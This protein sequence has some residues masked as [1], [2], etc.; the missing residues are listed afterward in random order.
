MK[1]S[2]YSILVAINIKP[3][4][5]DAFI[6]ASIAEAK[7]SIKE[8]PEIFQFQMAVD[9]TDPNRFYFFEIFKNKGANEDHWEAE[10]FKTW[11]DTVEE[12][13]DG[14]TER[15]CTMR[16]IFPSVSGLEKQKPGL[17]NW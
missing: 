16:T 9:E 2:M 15:I 4:C 11:W 13:F 17:M 6:E 10:A 5:R 7:G 12:M 1:D 8:E 14:G 3:E